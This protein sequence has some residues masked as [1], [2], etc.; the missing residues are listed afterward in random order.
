M[1]LIFI[2]SVM[3]SVMMIQT[4]K[5]AIMMVGTAVDSMLLQIFVMN[6]SAFKLK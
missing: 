2:M 5:S 6:A 3:V 1:S 4:L